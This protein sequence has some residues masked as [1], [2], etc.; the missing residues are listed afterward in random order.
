VLL[1]CV[2]AAAEPGYHSVLEFDAKGDGVT[3][4]TAPFQQAL[5]ATAA[6]GGGVVRVPTGKYLIKTHLAVPANVTLEGVWRAPVRGVPHDGGSTLL[7]VEG[8]GE[9]DGTPFITL[10]SSSVLKGLTIFYPEQ[11]RANP[12]HAYPWTV[13]AAPNTDNCTILDV[14]MVNPYQAVDFGTHA[15]GRHYVNR[16]YGYPL[17]KGL[18]IN[19]CYDVGRIEN[20]HFWPFWD[21]DPS[22]PLWTF[23]KENATAFI[24]GRT[25]GQMASNCFSIFYHVGMHFIAGP[26]GGRDRTEA[27]SGVYT[28]CYMDVTPCAVKVAQVAAGSGVSFVNGMLMSGVEVGPENRGPVKFTGCGFWAVRG[29]ERHARLQGRGTVIFNSCHF[30]NWDQKHTGAPCIYADN[31]QLIVTSCDFNTDRSDRCKV[32]LGPRVRAAVISSNLMGHGVLV[33]N[34]APQSADVQIGLNASVEAHGLLPEWLVLGA[35][36][37]PEAKDPREG[38][39]SRL[40]YDTDYLAALGGEM[41][42]VLTPDAEVAYVDAEDAPGL[43]ETRALQCGTSH[44]IDLKAAFPGGRGVAYAFCYLVSERDQ[45]A[46]LEFGANDCSKVWVNGELVHVYWNERGGSSRPGTHCFEAALHQGLNPVLVKVEDAGG[47][48]WEFVLEAYGADGDPIPTV[49]Q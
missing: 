35:F 36:P 7:A 14:T 12:P 10:N 20:I 5:D 6:D 15:T 1:F 24:I 40:G 4:D 37:N 42:A 43:A 30:S 26:I 21:I 47:R 16:L 2:A 44:R 31:S 25:D 22:S 9:A 33:D 27:G 32:G 28:N 11:V 17:Y 39:A 13:R 8:Q 41:A 34:R 18:Y 23:T 49:L 19:Q 45:T 38:G 48:L 46:R 29:L 3:D